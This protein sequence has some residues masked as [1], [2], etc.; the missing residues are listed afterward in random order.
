MRSRPVTVL[1]SLSM[2]CLATFLLMAAASCAIHAGAVSVGR[3]LSWPNTLL[4][5][6]V[7]PHNIGT[8]EKPFYEGTPLNFAAYI[9]SIPLSV[10]VYSLVAYLFIRHR[11]RVS[12]RL[13][14]R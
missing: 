7:L 1:M 10:F 2:G 4:Q 5:S 12:A 3:K 9:A 14:A 6:F 13:H 11:E 8:A